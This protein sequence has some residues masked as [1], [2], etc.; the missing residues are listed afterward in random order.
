MLK[1]IYKNNCFFLSSTSFEQVRVTASTE[2]NS[3]TYLGK[4]I[5]EDKCNK[6][7]FMYISY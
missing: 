6:N 4:F 7:N 5:V 3:L 2:D 1:L